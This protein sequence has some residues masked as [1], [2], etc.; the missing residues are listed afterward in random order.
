MQQMVYF[1]ALSLEQDLLEKLSI[2]IK[3]FQRD[4]YRCSD[5]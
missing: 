1:L 4:I 5:E 2:Q 3:R